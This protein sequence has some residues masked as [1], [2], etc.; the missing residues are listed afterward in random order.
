MTKM[1]WSLGAPASEYNYACFEDYVL[2]RGRSPGSKPLTTRELGVVLEAARRA[3]GCFPQGYCFANAATLV[4]SDTTGEITYVEGFAMGII[5]VHHAWAIIS[6]KVID[7]TWHNDSSLV[8][9]D[10]PYAENV[11]GIIPAGKAYIGVPFSREMVLARLR[12]NNP[13]LSL[14]DDWVDHYPRLKDPRKNPLP[15]YVM[16]EK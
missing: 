15:H 10:H 11:L 7:L 8:V 5:P 1:R 3:G 12:N 13:S 16:R 2:D 6:D 4:A 9:M 14:L